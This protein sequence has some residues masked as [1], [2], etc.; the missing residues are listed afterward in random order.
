M[1]DE[2]VVVNEQLLNHEKFTLKPRKFV[3]QAIA[4]EKTAPEIKIARREAQKLINTPASSR[5]EWKL[6][7]KRFALE[8]EVQQDEE[9]QF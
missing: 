8:N 5:R 3:Y 6:G 9:E 7:G 4:A 1:D 2:D